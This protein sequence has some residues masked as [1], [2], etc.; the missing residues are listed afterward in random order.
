VER[1]QDTLTRSAPRGEPGNRMLAA[2]RL[3]ARSLSLPVAFS[4]GTDGF[5]VDAG[6]VELGAGARAA[7]E[8]LCARA[9]AGEPVCT[10]RMGKA[11]D[12]AP[13]VTAA[14]VPVP[15]GCIGVAGVRA[16]RWSQADRAALEDAAALAAEPPV[17]ATTKAERTAR[18]GYGVFRAMFEDAQVGLAVLDLGG[19]ILRANGT[20]AR[21]LGI[22]PRR[23][24]GRALSAFVAG[25]D[26]EA[27]AM[28]A[29]LD[30]CADPG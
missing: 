22:R 13:L 11:E 10:G 3:A 15:G 20:L 2:A 26:A 4:H 30:A 12:A 5:S 23:L 25:D 17:P 6:G 14:A 29:E 19:R 21:M 27:A 16:R 24:F 9:S 8:R 1:S 18:P 28:R 7:L